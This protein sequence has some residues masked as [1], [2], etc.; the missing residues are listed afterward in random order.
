MNLDANATGLLI[1]GAIVIVGGVLEIFGAHKHR[2][3]AVKS[4]GWPRAG[5]EVIHRDLKR[6][7]LQGIGQVPR[8]RYSFQA[9]GQ[10]WEHDHVVFGGHRAMQRRQA[11]K[12]LSRYPT[13]SK[14]QVIH[15]PDDPR[16]CALE[17]DSAFV[18]PVIYGAAMMLTGAIVIVAA[19]TGF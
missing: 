9:G 4:R 3:I 18:A 15:N 19:V 8:V 7:F 13:G 5:G 12:I 6:T 1:V 11:E 2:Q 17:S 10:R 16:I 14:V